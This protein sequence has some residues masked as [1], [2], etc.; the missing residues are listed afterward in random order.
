MQADDLAAV[1]L[2]E[3]SLY[4]FPWSQQN[5][6]ESLQSNY[7]GLCLY[8]GPRLIGYA[9]QMRVMDETHLLNLSI[10]SA[11]QGKGHGRQLLQACRLQAESWSCQ[12]MLLEVRPSNTVARLF[13]EA[14]GFK[15]VGLRKGYYPALDGREDALVMFWIF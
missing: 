15:Q 13:Y 11:E 6:F 12:G 8:D 9:V 3:R 5:F 2:I 4:P 7:S 10:A 14:I 1:T